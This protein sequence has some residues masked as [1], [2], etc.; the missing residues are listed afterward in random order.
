[1]TVNE[2][3]VVQ[4]R[5]SGVVPAGMAELAKSKVEAVL[6]HVGEPV[7]S[8][9]VMLSR[10]ADPAVDRQAIAWAVIS[11][12]GRMVRA[13]GVGSTM[14]E[15]IAQLVARLRIRLE[16]VWPDER[17]QR[18]RSVANRRLRRRD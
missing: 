2:T 6:R 8:A 14:H 5:I 12:N 9:R 7:L 4:V 17:E 1:M 13:S 3:G 18:R 10:A 16:R 11:V 15:A